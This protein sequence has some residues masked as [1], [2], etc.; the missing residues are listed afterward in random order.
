MITGDAA[1][2]VLEGCHK[3][4]TDSLVF[5]LSLSLSFYG[6][7]R[8]DSLLV[9]LLFYSSLSIICMEGTYL[10]RFLFLLFLLFR[11]VGDFYE[12]GEE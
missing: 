1:Y 9:L 4:Q 12:Y 5:S 11:G 6:S 2:S 10:S 8:V 7:L 3:S